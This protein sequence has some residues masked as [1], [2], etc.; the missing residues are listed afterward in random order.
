MGA[1]STIKSPGWAFCRIELKV[2]KKKKTRGCL[3]DGKLAEGEVVA[4]IMLPL[5]P[6]QGQMAW[7][8]FSEI[9]K[10]ANNCTIQYQHETERNTYIRDPTTINNA[11]IS[12]CV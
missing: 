5:T 8:R 12:Y 11:R 10:H 6:P 4:G 2:F 7:F 1:L 9:I 3:R